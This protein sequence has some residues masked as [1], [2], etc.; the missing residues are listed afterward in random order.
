MQTFLRGLDLDL[1]RVLEDVV[2]DF[3]AIGVDEYD[4]MYHHIV[5]MLTLMHA[6]GWTGMDYPTLAVE[7]GVGLSSGVRVS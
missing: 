3:R 1:V 5:V 6:A 2:A 4:M 7:S